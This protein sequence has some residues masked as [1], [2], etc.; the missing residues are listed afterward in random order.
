[1]LKKDNLMVASGCYKCKLL[2]IKCEGI[3]A[4]EGVEIYKCKYF[5]LN[6]SNQI[7]KDNVKVPYPLIEKK[8][9]KKK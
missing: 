8:V 6:N 1:M 2:N 3:F 7:I 4:I 5:I 9:R